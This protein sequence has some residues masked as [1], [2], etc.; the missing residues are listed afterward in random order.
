[1]ETLDS[2]KAAFY[3][4]L[5]YRI[6]MGLH[7]RNKSYIARR[8]GLTE[9]FTLVH[10]ML[11]CPVYHQIKLMLVILKIPGYACIAHTPHDQDDIV[12]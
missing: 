1:M 6:L 3:R 4:I 7:H 9:I 12:H 10:Q 5:V 8:F 2:L 11:S